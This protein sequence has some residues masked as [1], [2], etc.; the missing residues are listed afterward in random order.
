MSFVGDEDDAVVP[1]QPAKPE[2]VLRP[3]P[4][5]KDYSSNV[6]KSTE[7]DFTSLLTH[8]VG[9][10]WTVDYYQQILGTDQV[11]TP[12]QVTQSEVYQQYREIFGFDLKV[13]SPIN[14]TQNEENGRFEVV[15]TA[16]VIP[17]FKPNEGDMFIADVGDGRAGIFTISKKPRQLTI[18]LES[19]YEIEYQMTTFATHEKVSELKDKVVESVHYDKEAHRNN[20]EAFVH[21]DVIER[22][23]EVKRRIETL[24]EAY[25]REFWDKQNDTLGLDLGEGWIYDD[26]MV[27]FIK[28]LPLPWRQEPDALN[29]NGIL[30]DNLPTIWETFTSG[31]QFY[32]GMMQAAHKVNPRNYGQFPVFGGVAWTAVVWI[33]KDVL[34]PAPID[35]EG[36]EKPETPVNVH[37]STADGWYVF[38]SH[39][40]RE[41]W[42]Y[43]SKLELLTKSWFEGKSLEATSLLELAEDVRKWDKATR[44]FQTP[45][46]LMLLLNME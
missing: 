3:K 20:G 27:R 17:S 5:P 35:I 16:T 11:G 36:L 6:V 44:F 40:Y 45:I 34:A 9:M 4:E 28:K 13:V 10:R 33:F 12:Q 43:C 30:D 29:C 24:T 42:D 15:G 41:E 18:Y 46:L 2:P 25:M 26:W 22:R 19:G 32:Y 39:Y 21:A 8:A 1:E 7:I 38:S 37:P 14:P 31:Q 23:V